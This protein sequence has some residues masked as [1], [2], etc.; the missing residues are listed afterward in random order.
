MVFKLGVLNV[1]EGQFLLKFLNL[2]SLLLDL[3]ILLLKGGRGRVRAALGYN[4][5][6]LVFFLEV[7]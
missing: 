6:P 5:L 2:F 7:R 3:L 4:P 1:S